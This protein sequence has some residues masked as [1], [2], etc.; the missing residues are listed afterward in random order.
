MKFIFLLSLPLYFVDQVTKT[1][2]LRYVD[3]TQP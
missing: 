3:P 1:S 2:I